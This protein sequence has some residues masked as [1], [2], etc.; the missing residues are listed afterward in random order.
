MR[1]EMLIMSLWSDIHTDGK[2]NRKQIDTKTISKSTYT[3]VNRNLCAQMRSE[4]WSK[5]SSKM[6]SK[7]AP[8]KT[9]ADLK[10]VRRKFAQHKILAL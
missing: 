4:T 6:R 9:C 2:L 8:F 7:V 1:L 10:M 5:L 3:N